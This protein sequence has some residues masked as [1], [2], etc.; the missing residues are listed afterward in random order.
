MG[1]AVRFSMAAKVS[2]RWGNCKWFHVEQG[3]SIKIKPLV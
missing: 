2:R 1:Q 3:D